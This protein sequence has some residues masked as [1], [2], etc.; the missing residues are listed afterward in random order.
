[1]MRMIEN[2]VP[3]PFGWKWPCRHATCVLPGY[4]RFR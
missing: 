4:R 1:M 2:S 3:F